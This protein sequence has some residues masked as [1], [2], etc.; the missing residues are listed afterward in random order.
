MDGYKMDIKLD[1]FKAKFQRLNTE[2]FYRL[3]MRIRT[4]QV[5]AIILMIISLL[6]SWLIGFRTGGFC[7]ALL[8]AFVIM[9]RLAKTPQ[10]SAYAARTRSFDVLF[11]LFLMFGIAV[12][13]IIAPS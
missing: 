6:L 1:A 12:L 4:L 3:P 5:I 2:G 13:S 9:V 10:G 7:I 8:L 11:L